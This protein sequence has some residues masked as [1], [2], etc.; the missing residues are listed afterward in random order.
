M[1]KLDYI[2]REDAAELIRF[3]CKD[4]ISKGKYNVEVTEFN[5]DI[6]KKLVEI[7]AAD[8]VKVVRCK[9][10]EYGEDTGM[11]GMWCNHP[12]N[13]NPLGC[14]PDDFCNDWKR[15]DYENDR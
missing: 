10:C 1:N 6:Q 4:L 11:S 15:K 14:R 2:K 9:D 8:V 5:S 12:D 7:T 13:R 3:Y